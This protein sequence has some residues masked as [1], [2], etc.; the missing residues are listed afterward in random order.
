MGRDARC[1][2][3][4]NGD[5]ICHRLQRKTGIFIKRNTKCNKKSDFHDWTFFVSQSAIFDSIMTAF[6]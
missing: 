6:R 5:G 2:R 3:C 4:F 1:R